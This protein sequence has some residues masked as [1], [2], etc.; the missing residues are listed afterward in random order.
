MI[1]TARLL[2][3]P[4]IG[5]NNMIRKMAG[6][7]SGWTDDRDLPPIAKRTFSE[8]WDEKYAKRQQQTPKIKEETNDE[9]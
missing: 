1:K 2:Q 6:L 8:I 5:K 3:K 7:A 4:F 9:K